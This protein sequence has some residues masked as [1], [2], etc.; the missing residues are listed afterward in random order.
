MFKKYL[1][2]MLCTLLL[3]CAGVV[4]AMAGTAS[5]YY[6]KVT[7]TAT[8]NGYGK[9]YVSRESTNDPDYQNTSTSSGNLRYVGNPTLNFKFYA[10]AKDE[11]YIFS[12]WASGSANGTS[13][14]TNTSFNTDLEISSTSSSSPTTY[15]Y[16]AVFIAQ[17][18]LIKVRSADE[19]KGSVNIN[20]PNNIENDEV[21]LTA[22]PDVTNGVLFLGWKKNNEDGSNDGY[23]SKDNP[24]VLTAGS[25]TKGTYYAYFSNPQERTYIRLQ[26]IKTG[27]FLCIYGNQQATVHY[28]TKDGNTRQD[29][30]TFTNSLK[31][32]AKDEAQGNPATVFLRAGNPSGS[33]V[34]IGG[35]LTAH[36]V[37][38]KTHLVKNNNYPLT[39]VNTDKGVRIY[40]NFTYSGVTF[41][42]YLCDED[43]N[44]Q[45]AVMKSFGE[46]DDDAATYW[47]LYSLD[48]VTTEGAFGANAKA[49]YT[50]EGKY[51]TTMYTDFPYK[52]LDGVNAYYLTIP[53]GG[54]EELEEEFD[55]H[56]VVFMQ[57]TGGKV[58]ANMAVILECPVVQNDINST[59]VVTNRLQPLTETVAPIVDQGLNFLKGYISLNNR[60]V[61]NDKNRMYILSVNKAGVLGFYHSTAENMTPNKA[62]LLAPEVS[63]EEEEYYS[64]N[65]TFSFGMPE[66]D[67]EQ[68]TTEIVLSEQ[69]VDCEDAPVYDLQGRIVAVGKAAEN[70][71]RQGIYV[72][73]GKKFIVK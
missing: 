16:Y 49:K 1:R 54:K 73:K 60:K 34:T 24:L 20:N 65:L 22:N 18:G 40:T 3:L 32:I 48:D 47:S 14:S 10:Q 35:D 29:G 45:Y 57:V 11:N 8:P 15:N 26:N 43:G 63:K 55:H 38:Y 70:L 62:Y 17:Q 61:T 44:T 21:T 71:L 42:S 68:G 6:F 9:V 69:M 51:Y 27:R 4:S 66:D 41:S 46:D 2:R 56:N 28:R 64:K 31:L 19:S 53:E 72:K 30:F 13:V 39:M 58:P 36:G 23:Y 37:S 59:S 12:H 5:D 67:D 33:G 7:A 25:D 50:K 52:L